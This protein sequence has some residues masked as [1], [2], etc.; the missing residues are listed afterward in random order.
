MLWATHD[1]PVKDTTERLVLIA[2]ADKADSD[3]CNAFPSK[4][5]I[6]K[7]A[8]CDEK[9]AQRKLAELR[10]RGLI[11]FGD[12]EAARYIEK[13]Y[14][15]KVYDLLIPYSW[16]GPERVARVNAE[17]KGK[18]L[19]PLSP[20]NR[21]AIEAA[22]VKAVRSDKGKPRPKKVAAAPRQ[23]GQ[24]APPGSEAGGT[25]S[26]PSEGTGSPASGGTENPAEGGLAVPQTVP[27][28][29]RP[30]TRAD[31]SV[32]VPSGTAGLSLLLAF[33]ATERTYLLVGAPLEEN[34]ARVDELLRRGWMPSQVRG[35]LAANL[36]ERSEL[37]TSPAAIVSYRLRKLLEAPVPGLQGLQVPDPR[38]DGGEGVQGNGPSSA[39][40]VEEAVS[41]SWRRRFAECEGKDGGCGRMVVPGHTLCPDCIGWD[42]CAN[43]CGRVVDPQTGREMCP[44]CAGV[45]ELAGGPPF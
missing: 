30:V 23:G 41:G 33:G 14:R 39:Y 11:D 18:G 24:T 37:R 28:D 5:T 32:P 19:P 6:A 13:R 35:V 7:V 22:P 20:E 45:L 16:Y 40:S 25:H 2:L 15:P 42:R 31:G 38:E 4:K 44:S 3:G 29:P 43:G 10:K 26:P 17:R 12:Q 34:A 36:P 1:S 27:S 9:T 21:P 8:L